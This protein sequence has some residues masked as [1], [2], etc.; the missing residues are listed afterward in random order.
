M[1]TPRNSSP[2]RNVSI[3]TLYSIGHCAVNK[4]RNSHMIE[5]TLDEDHPFADGHLVS[6]S[7][8]IQVEGQ[9]AAGAKYNESAKV[10]KTVPAKFLNV[11]YTNR[12]TSPDIRRGERVIVYRLGNTDL[13]YWTPWED[14]PLKLRKLETVIIAISAS[15][16]E[17]DEYV[18]ENNNPL[19]EYC[20][21]FTMSSHDK[22]I[23]LHTSQADGEPAGYDICLDTE[24]GI[25]TFLDTFDNSIKVHSEESIIQFINTHKTEYLADKQNLTLNVPDTFTVNCKKY[26]LTATTSI[27]ETTATR[28]SK[29]SNTKIDSKLNITGKTKMDNDLDV[30]GN[31]HSS[32]TISDSD[33]SD[34]A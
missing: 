31:V 32:G 11:G 13:Y 34:T 16:N 10:T 15:K 5:V 7:S 17:D 25:F 33:G 3:F 8:D 19:E 22:Q 21:Y 23:R 14:N 29:A 1:V 4:P 27:S 26:N 18:G 2:T 6:D 12:I 30:D 20:Y 28:T 9:D 24:L